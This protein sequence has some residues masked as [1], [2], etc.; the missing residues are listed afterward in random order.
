MAT[1]R[2]TTTTFGMLVFSMLVFCSAGTARSQPFP[3]TY[4]R[5]GSAVPEQTRGR[6]VRTD[7]QQRYYVDSLGR[8]YLIVREVVQPS[9][10]L[11]IL[12]YIE[13]DDRPYYIDEDQRLYTRDQSGR[14]SYIDEVGQDQVNEPR[15]IMRRGSP[16][17]YN[18]PMMQSESCASQYAKCMSGCQGISRKE[19]YTKPT[20]INN[21][22]VIRNGCRG[23]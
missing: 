5:P 7:T 2:S 20:C 22:E 6:F 19:S 4:A 23:Q 1:T 9:A 15:V 21:C 12:Y 10:P 16:S 18:Q 13:N 8:R 11:G 14:M 17:M 3:E